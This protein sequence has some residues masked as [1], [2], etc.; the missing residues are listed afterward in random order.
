MKIMFLT[1][2]QIK[3][4]L[5]ENKLGGKTLVMISHFDIFPNLKSYQIPPL[6]DIPQFRNF[7]F[8]LDEQ[9]FRSESYL[10]KRS[11]NNTRPYLI[12]L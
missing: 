1:L 7:P 8:R 11:L 2:R 4:S 3:F 12:K 6:E 5:F 10:I 9:T